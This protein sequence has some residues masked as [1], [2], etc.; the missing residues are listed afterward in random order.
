MDEE[1]FFCDIWVILRG[2]WDLHLSIN[3]PIQACISLQEFQVESRCLLALSSKLNEFTSNQQLHLE[4][5]K[6]WKIK[7]F[8]MFCIEIDSNIVLYTE[9]ALKLQ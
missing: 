4:L 1:V 7:F 6:R 8:C 3:H 5:G 9:N 2:K